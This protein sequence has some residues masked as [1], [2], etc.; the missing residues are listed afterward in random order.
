MQSIILI[1]FRGAG[2]S[3]IGAILAQGLGWECLDSDESIAHAHGFE[4]SCDMYAA[5]GAE[6]FRKAEADWIHSLSPERPAAISVG[7]G[8]PVHSG[9]ELATKGRVVLLDTDPDLLW[10]RFQANPPVFMAERPTKSAFHMLYDQRFDAYD[11]IADLSF[12]VS[13]TDTPVSVRDRI[14]EAING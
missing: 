1:G 12:T 5:L 7:G 9:A 13:K 14:M 3:T 4:A 2:K 6:A 8:L 11:Q 10:L